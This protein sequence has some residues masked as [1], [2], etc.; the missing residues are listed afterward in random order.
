MVTPSPWPFLVSLHVFI[1]ILGAISYMHFI[2]YGGYLLIW[3]LLN[4]IFVV[5]LWLRDVIREGTF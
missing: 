5:I 1:M 3:G 4:V 2:I